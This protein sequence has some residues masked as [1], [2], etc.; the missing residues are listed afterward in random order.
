MKTW[1]VYS[2]LLCVVEVTNSDVNANDFEE[3]IDEK[4]GKTVLRMKKEVAERKG[5]GDMDNVDFEYVID[6]KTGQQVIQ[7][8]NNTGKL[9]KGH[10]S[11][12]MITDPTTGKQTLRMKQEVEVKCKSAVD[13]SFPRILFSSRSVETV[14]NDLS[15]T[16]FEE[17]IDQVTGERILKLTAEAAAR[18]GLTDLREVAFE[19]Y[20]DPT[21]GKEQ[22]RMKGGNQTGKLAGDQK[23][24][25][26]VDSKTGQQKIVLKRPKGRTRK[27]GIVILKSHTVVF[28]SSTSREI[29]R[30]E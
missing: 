15:T 30:C 13:F 20:V 28:F 17:V 4:T 7:I 8:K 16:D 29:D 23:F 11:F 19:V 18:K 9:N 21:T 3:I 22:I 25:I 14:E 27:D 6:Q 10:V 26:Y 5:F 12:E 1:V 24:E 2:L